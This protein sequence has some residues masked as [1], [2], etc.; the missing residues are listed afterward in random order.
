[1][2]VAL[3]NAESLIVYLRT[4]I[5]NMGR[6]IIDGKRDFKNK[7]AYTLFETPSTIANPVIISN[8]MAMVIF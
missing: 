5:V 1:M 3:Q 8:K 6:F 4:R 7:E 2:S